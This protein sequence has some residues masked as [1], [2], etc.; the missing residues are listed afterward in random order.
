M[1][2]L[3]IANQQVVETPR[4]LASDSKLVDMDEP[5]APFTPREVETF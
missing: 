5:I 3:S 4:S 1:R 2:G